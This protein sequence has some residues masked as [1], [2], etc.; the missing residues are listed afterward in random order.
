MHMRRPALP[1]LVLLLV[2]MATLAGC[3]SFDD[4]DGDGIYD[5]DDPDDD[6]DGMPDK[7]EKKHGLGSKNESDA[8]LDPDGDSLTNLE[9]YVN[10]T[11]PNS[12]DT[13]GD[14][15][16]DGWEV[17]HGLDPTNATSATLDDDGDGLTAL[18]EFFNSTDPADP[19]SDD[20]GI[21]DGYEV[22]HGLNP[23]D[24]VDGMRDDDQDGLD[25]L[26]EFGAN[27]DPDDDD[28]DDDGIPDGW[29]VGMGLDP[30]VHDSSEDPD[31]DGW[32][33]DHDAVLEHHEEFTNL[34]EYWNDTDPLDADTDGDGMGDGF[35]A[36][37]GL[38]PLDEDDKNEDP[39]EDGL[40]N[41]KEHLAKTSP[42]DADTDGDGMDDAFERRWALNPLSNVDAASDMDGDDFTNLEEYEAGTNISNEDTDGDGVKDGRDVVPLSD[43]AIRV[44]ITHLSFDAMVEGVIDNPNVSKPYEVYIRVEVGGLVAWSDVLVTSDLDQDTEF[45]LVVDIP[46]DIWTVNISI[47]L[48]ENDTAESSGLNADDHLDVDGTSDDLDCDILYDL[49][50]ATWTGDTTTGST[51]G[52][53]D[54]QP[55]DIDHPDGALE[56]TVEV[57]PA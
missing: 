24:L 33:K 35:E 44:T 3:L 50:L 2:I 26:E 42:V 10:G 18:E 56:F 53:D 27:T 9:E 54:G 8:K 5:E 15:A 25:N 20:D 34:Q 32:D 14:G 30:L 11:D 39:D 47:A 13:D 6:N 22:T 37:Y 52:H 19:D 40:S 16:P 49:V 51:D 28:S 31:N 48:W 43:I 57:V 36:L 7:W 12:D 41:G 23:L 38:L 45:L 17:E 55:P 29:E 1:L 21:W 4:Y 46:D